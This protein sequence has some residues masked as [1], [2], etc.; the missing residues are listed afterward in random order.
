MTA[1]IIQFPGA[2]YDRDVMARINKLCDEEMDLVFDFLIKMRDNG[3][4]LEQLSV[5]WDDLGLPTIENYTSHN[6]K[7]EKE[8]PK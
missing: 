6:R 4:N 3:I 5:E 1:K 8:L 2:F 7:I